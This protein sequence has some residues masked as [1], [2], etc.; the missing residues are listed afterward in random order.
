M[1]IDAS[2]M[3]AYSAELRTYPNR[4]GKRAADA[5]R[6][7]AKAVEQAAKNNVPVRTGTLR[8]SIHTETTGGGS[9]GS[10]SASVVTTEKYAGFVEFGDGRGPPQPFMGPALDSQEG[11]FYSAMEEVAA[12]GLGG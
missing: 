5:V 1:P 2:Q 9:S 11:Q 10:I 4:L 6:Q 3:F 8:N 7:Q 12:D